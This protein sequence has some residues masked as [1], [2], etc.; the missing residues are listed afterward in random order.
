MSGSGRAPLREPLHGANTA[1]RPEQAA[2]FLAQLK[3]TQRSLK[4]VQPASNAPKA[5]SAQDQNTRPPADGRRATRGEHTPSVVPPAF[6]SQVRAQAKAPG[7]EAPAARRGGDNA[8]VPGRPPSAGG[9][10]PAPSW[11]KRTAGT[12]FACLLY[13]SPSPRDRG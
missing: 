3:Q 1:A 12:D 9:A 6:A 8:S 4:H 7:A 13:T 10:D 5:L 2:P 11:K